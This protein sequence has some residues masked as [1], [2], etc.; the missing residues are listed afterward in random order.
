MTTS[1]SARFACNYVLLTIHTVAIT[2]NILF[3]ASLVLFTPYTA[4]WNG[5]SD[6]E[7]GLY[8]FSWCIGTSVGSCDLLP[9]SD[10]HARLGLLTRESWTNTGLASFSNLSDGS[11]YVTVQAISN[12]EYGGLLVTTVHHSTPYII[13]TTPPTIT[14]VNNIQFNHSTNELSLDYVVRD[15]GSGIASVSIAIG[16]TP[17][18]TQLLY[19]T[20]LGLGGS[21]LV[22]VAIP[23]G[24]PGWVK[25]RVVNNGK[26]LEI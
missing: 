4:N 26:S 22:T 20:D 24:V 17:R 19:W 8:A 23:D 16:R 15:E 5:F 7:S 1:Y 12:I 6:P 18:D 11:Y 21:G 9:P 10:P 3:K 25:L 2:V 14:E 13:D